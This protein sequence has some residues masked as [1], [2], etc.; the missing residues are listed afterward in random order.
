VAG[1]ALAGAVLSVPYLVDRALAQARQRRVGEEAARRARDAAALARD[2]LAVQTDAVALMTR[3]V[4]ANPR[5]V[6]AL[7]GRVSRGTF[8][9]LLATESWWEPYRE[10]QTAISYDGATLAFAQTDGLDGVAVAPIVKRVSDT[11]RA[12]SAVMS[13]GGGAFLVAACPAP[14]GRDRAAVLALA[15]RIDSALLRQV[16]GG[17]GRAVLLSDGRQSLAWG[18]VD[19]P[20]LEPLVGR[21]ARASV[22]ALEG[23]ATQAAAVAVAPG[24]WLWAIGRATDFERAAVAADGSRRKVAW[25]LAVAIAAA[26]AALSLR[27]RRRVGR[28]ALVSVPMPAIAAVAAPV[29]VDASAPRAGVTVAVPPAAVQASAPSAEIVRAGPGT[30]LGRYLL[31][32]RI[33]IGGMAEVFTAVSFGYGGFRR[34]FVIKR[35]RAELDGNPTAVGLFIDEANLA[36]TL[37][38]PNV[39]PVFD[40]GES[41]G[42]YFLAEEYIVGRDLGR[43][44]NRL[45]DRGEPLLSRDAILHLA[46]EILN[47]LAYAHDKRD[48]A[49]RPIGLVHRDIT[50]E[51]VII[52]ERGEVKILDFGIM[53]ARQRVS[54]TESG[55]VR[56]NVGFMSPEQARGRAVDHRSDLY[57]TG[58][59]LLFAA[60]GEPTHPGETFYD[61]LTAAAAGPGERQRAR[62]AALPAPLPAILTRALAVDPDERFQSS[63]EFSAAIAP[64]LEGGGPGE[65]ATQIAALF[66]EELRAEQERL[67]AALPRTPRPEPLADAGA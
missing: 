49:G 4:V 9:D 63:A 22:V 55:T 48:D 2:A 16:A 26:I 30:T 10:L 59:V 60:T 21:E 27:S 29:V 13:G 14:L 57:S 40:F 62:I 15:R 65:L 25:S 31:V 39:V 6:A 32:D 52:S 17:P 5:F 23:A 28:P 37:V 45:K 18:G 20:Q 34:P 24:L 3:N 54:Q 67:A 43:L 44:T 8:A 1:L 53:K 61:L 36:S 56:G 42:S 7:R 33:G 38:H 50:P 11:G 66:G 41:G 51:N 64:H 58:L 12:A 19:G 46:R 47:G 35:L